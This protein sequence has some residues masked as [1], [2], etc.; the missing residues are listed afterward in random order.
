M[1]SPIASNPETSLLQTDAT[2]DE[3][4]A[5]LLHNVTNDP[6]SPQFG[7]KTRL[8]APSAETDEFSKAAIP[9]KETPA[10]PKDIRQV[11]DEGL[12]RQYFTVEPVKEREENKI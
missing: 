8:S 10:F 1:A 3:V 11:P 7:A 9:F 5:H 12:N 4:M 2:Q 6:D